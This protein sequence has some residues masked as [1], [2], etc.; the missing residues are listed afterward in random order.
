MPADERFPGPICGQGA[1]PAEGRGSDV[2]IRGHRSLKKKTT[3][4]PRHAGQKNNERMKTSSAC[5]AE[6]TRRGGSAAA[7][8][9]A[10]TYATPTP[11]PSPGFLLRCQAGG[12]GERAFWPRFTRLPPRFKTPPKP[13]WMVKINEKKNTL[14][15]FISWGKGSPQPIA[16]PRRARR[17]E[18]PLV[19]PLS[20][21]ASGHAAPRARGNAGRGTAGRD[22]GVCAEQRRRKGRV[23]SR[24]EKRVSASGK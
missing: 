21:P 10:P 16:P 13:H 24:R 19:P 15:G 3:T 18:A 5:P 17:P 4:P 9:A 6:V 23:T 8:R 11:E 12:D 7:R 22:G 2:E 14:K 1:R 20:L